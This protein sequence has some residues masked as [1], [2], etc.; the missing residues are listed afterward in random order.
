MKRSAASVECPTVNTASSGQEVPSPLSSRA[1]T[2]APDALF[3]GARVR[4]K[5]S[6]AQQRRL[7]GGRF[8]QP[9]GHRRKYRPKGGTPHHFAEPPMMRGSPFRSE[10]HTSE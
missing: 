9:P 3:I 2:A 7:A 4:P 5:G 10:D 8:E 1:S 6:A